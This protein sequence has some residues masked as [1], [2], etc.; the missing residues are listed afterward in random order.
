MYLKTGMIEEEHI[1]EGI[2]E[3]SYLRKIGEDGKIIEE[4]KLSRTELVSFHLNRIF[5]DSKT[6]I[7]HKGA[8]DKGFP[9]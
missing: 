1:K 7:P 3:T 2:H 9:L 8:E 4:K 5:P 6:D